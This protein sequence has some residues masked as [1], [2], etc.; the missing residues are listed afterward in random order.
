M[1]GSRAVELQ[2]P[3]SWQAQP[4]DYAAHVGKLLRLDDA[5]ARRLCRRADGSLPVGRHNPLDRALQ[6]VG[7]SGAVAFADKVEI[8]RR[9]FAAAM[10]ER[11]E[12]RRK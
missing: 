2:A 12:L 6:A 5:R 7:S 3:L 9:A 1:Q 4:K 10:Q 8:F 11:D